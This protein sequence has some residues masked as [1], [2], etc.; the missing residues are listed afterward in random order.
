MIRAEAKDIPRI[1]QLLYA[2]EGENR[3]PGG[4][5]ELQAL[6]SQSSDVSIKHTY[7]KIFC[8]GC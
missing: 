5:Q 4:G 3:R 6:E 2:G 7:L 1:F 8:M